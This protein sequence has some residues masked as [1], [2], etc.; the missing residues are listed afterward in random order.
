M[1]LDRRLPSAVTLDPGSHQD[2]PRQG[3]WH[4]LVRVS[5]QLVVLLSSAQL[6]V[7]PSSERGCSVP[8]AYLLADHRC[9]APYARGSARSG[10]AGARALQ[11]RCL[12]RGKP[13]VGRHDGLR[14]GKGG[15]TR[16][17]QPGLPVVSG[18]GYGENF[19][20]S[21]EHGK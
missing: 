16:D 17:G 2:Q 13:A 15:D 9:Q 11:G 21:Q 8:S 7:R 12:A 5:G 19:C 3:H 1:I 20:L 6:R 4:R 10:S 14:D 18:R